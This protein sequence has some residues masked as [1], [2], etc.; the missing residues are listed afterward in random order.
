MVI[1]RK[2]PTGSSKADAGKTG[3]GLATDIAFHGLIDQDRC[4]GGS[5][6]SRPHPCVAGRGPLAHHK[7]HHHEPDSP[8]PTDFAR[9]PI[10]MVG[11]GSNRGR[12]RYRPD[13]GATSVR[14]ST[15]GTD[16]GR[17]WPVP[18]APRSTPHAAKGLIPADL[19][20]VCHDREAGT[21]EKKPR[22]APIPTLIGLDSRRTPPRR[23]H[24]PFRIIE[25]SP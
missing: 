24:I 8:Q 12:M 1:P 13:R 9:I 18:G 20:D 15:Y 22:L 11:R 16:R 4:S 6:D 7:G 2:R 21:A 3:R 14:V 25:P 5:S 17:S 23:G 10:P 19:Y